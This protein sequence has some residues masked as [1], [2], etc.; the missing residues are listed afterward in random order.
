M[1]EFNS[2]VEEILYDLSAALDAGDK[3]GIMDA[4]LL[5][6]GGQEDIDIARLVIGCHSIQET[7]AHVLVT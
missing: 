2:P 1:P 6:V 7:R 5:K 3:N 4:I